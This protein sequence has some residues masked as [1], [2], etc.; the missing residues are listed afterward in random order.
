MQK[1]FTSVS[2]LQV[3]DLISESLFTIFSFY[4]KG[5]GKAEP[6]R[7]SSLEEGHLLRSGAR[8]SEF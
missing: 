7:G 1:R 8:G 2:P 3:R 5:Q 4:H 6:W